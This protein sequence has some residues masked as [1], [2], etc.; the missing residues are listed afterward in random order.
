MLAAPNVSGRALA[1]SFASLVGS[2]R[3][4][5]DRESIKSIRAAFLEMYKDMVFA[6]VRDF[7]D[8][9]RSAA[10]G[11]STTQA[12]VVTRRSAPATGG[13]TA[14]GAFVIEWGRA[15]KGRSVPVVW[16]YLGQGPLGLGRQD[17]LSG[18]SGSTQAGCGS[19]PGHTCPALVPLGR[20]ARC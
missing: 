6:A 12:A 17:Y 20:T 2:D 7:I 3:R 5:I 1:E 8:A 11:A 14:S 4:R 10:T 15:A 19:W 16:G 13:A 9:Q 18:P